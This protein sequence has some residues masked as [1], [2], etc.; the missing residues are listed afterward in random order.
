VLA[1]ARVE[2]PAPA[3]PARTTR[4]PLEPV[5]YRF[6]VEEISLASRGRMLTR[7]GFDRAGAFRPAEV[8][9]RTAH[10]VPYFINMG[11]IDGTY[12]RD[13]RLKIDQS[14]SINPFENFAF[15]FSLPIDE[16]GRYSFYGKELFGDLQFRAKVIRP[17]IIGPE[18]FK[19]GLVDDYIFLNAAMVSLEKDKVTLQR[20]GGE[21][22][23]ITPFLETTFGEVDLTKFGDLDEV[24]L[25]FSVDAMARAT[26]V[27]KIRA[28]G[29]TEVFHLKA[30]APWAR[31]NPQGRYSAHV[32]VE[33]L[34]Q[35]RIF[36][37]FPENVS[38]EEMRTGAGNLRMKVFGIGF[39]E[40]ARLELVPEG[41]GESVW[42]RDE[43]I[44]VLMFN[45]GI[46]TRVVLPTEP[47][48]YTVRLHTAGTTATRQ[49][50]LRVLE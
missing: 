26:G 33:D 44:K 19:I 32:F 17:R 40:D 39:G 2:V 29:A 41:G 18:K 12:V 43:D 38:A 10:R 31:L 37:V 36:S 21:P 27:I 35:P 24:E 3:A 25:L 23:T 28:G 1:A 22:R 42:A 5:P 4:R 34:A 20:Q 15:D 6:E 14:C 8:A 13:G 16:R 11:Y 50:G 9:G 7:D 30:D 49:R 48:A 46:E 47:G 45:M